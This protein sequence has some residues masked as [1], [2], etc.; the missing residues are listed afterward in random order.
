VFTCDGCGAEA[1][2]DVALTAWFG[3]RSAAHG[4]FD[5]C[6]TCLFGTL[7]EATLLREKR[8]D[9]AAGEVWPDR[10]ACSIC[11]AP[12]SGDHIS[13]VQRERGGEEGA[14]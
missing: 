14:T 12:I 4:S 11:G 3:C 1:P 9:V 5:L 2:A 10:E 7:S 8:D 13:Q 6:P